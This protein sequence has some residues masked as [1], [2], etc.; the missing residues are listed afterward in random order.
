[1][2]QSL[3]RDLRIAA[4]RLI[5]TPLFTIFSILSLGVGIGVTTIA[6]SLV[7]GIFFGKVAI[8]DPASAVFVMASND[9]RIRFQPVMSR[10]DFEDL[11]ASQESLGTLAASWRFNPSVASS[12]TTE[13]MQ[14]EAVTGDYFPA[15]G[16]AAALGRTIQPADDEARA[17]VAVLS[18][19]LWR[20]RFASDPRI[21]GQTVRIGGHSFEIVGIAPKSFA[22]VATDFGASG[23]R[24]WVPLGTAPQFVSA[25]RWFDLPVGGAPP[26]R[27]GAHPI[28]DRERRDLMV[29]GRLRAGVA[30][31]TA[32]AELAQVGTRLDSS[33]PNTISF[34]G[35][36]TIPR[37]A[38]TARTVDDVRTE[39]VEYVQRMGIVVASLVCLV[40]VVACTNLANLVLA[41]GAT[42]RQEIAV[43]RALGASR[44]RLVREQASESLLIAIGGG[45]AAF[46]VMRALHAGQAAR[47]ERSLHRRMARRH[48]PRYFPDHRCPDSARAWF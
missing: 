4:R 31:E 16:V 30:A 2:T 28:P 12:A 8:H 17:A 9:G 14:A 42:R 34:R 5:A 38:W 10:P 19:E 41:R 37:R 11:R 22:G 15:L 6:Y 26:A 32:A 44:W 39:A 23:T 36:Q 48:D 1:V 29:I 33:Y 27:L 40:L 43:R 18:H 7:D 21:I 47:A 35:T 45:L 3:G 46:V 24:L 13:L 25:V 20:A